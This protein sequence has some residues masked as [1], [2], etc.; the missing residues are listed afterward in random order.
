M[1]ILPN[2]LPVSNSPCH[3]VNVSIGCSLTAFIKLI[4]NC[5]SQEGTANSQ[6]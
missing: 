5:G 1:R 4:L 6:C 2:T 3:S